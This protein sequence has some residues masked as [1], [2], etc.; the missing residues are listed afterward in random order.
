MIGSCGE[1]SLSNTGA[2]EAIHDSTQMPMTTALEED[3][4]S[5]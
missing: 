1:K 3:Y 4:V 5:S 2:L